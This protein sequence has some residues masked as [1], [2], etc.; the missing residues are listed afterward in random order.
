MGKVL[1]TQ[2]CVQFTGTKVDDDQVEWCV[3]D[4]RDQKRETKIPRRG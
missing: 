2:V 1:A 3:C 4:L